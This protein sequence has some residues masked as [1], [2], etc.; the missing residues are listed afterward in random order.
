MSNR[1]LSLLLAMF[2][3]LPGTAVPS[4][5][6]GD[7]TVSLPNGLRVILRPVASAQQTAVVTLFD[8]GNQLPGPRVRMTNG[9]RGQIGAP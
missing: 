2:A 5:V 4:A 1:A 7:T 8:V 6:A 3:V 9:I